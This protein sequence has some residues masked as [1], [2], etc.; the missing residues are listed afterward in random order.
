[1]E[2]WCHSAIKKLFHVTLDVDNENTHL[3]SLEKEL[4]EEGLVPPLKLSQSN[5]DRILL[6]RLFLWNKDSKS[7][8][9]DYLIDIYIN[10]CSYKESESSN[11]KEKNIFFDQAQDL[12]LNYIGLIL[13]MPTMFPQS[14]SIISLGSSLW[15]NSI[16]ERNC[17]KTLLTGLSIDPINSMIIHFE[18]S[19]ILYDVVSNGLLYLRDIAINTCSIDSPSSFGSIIETLCLICSYKQVSDI[20]VRLPSWCPSNN[21][22][23]PNFD[24]ESYLGPLLSIGFNLYDPKSIMLAKSHFDHARNRPISELESS[25]YH[26]RGSFHLLHKAI[27]KF[28]SILLKSSADNKNLVLQY[29]SVLL[30]LNHSRGKMM[31]DPMQVSSDST[32]LNLSCVLLLFCEPFIQTKRFSSVIPD[33][34]I[35]PS[36]LDFS[37]QTRM[38]ATQEQWNEYCKDH[39]QQPYSFITEVYFMTIESY[40]LAFNRCIHI[41]YDLNKNIREL[42][43]T[44]ETVQESRLLNILNERLNNT[45]MSKLVL[46]VLL[47]DKDIITSLDSFWSFTLSWMEKILINPNESILPWPIPPRLEWSCIPEPFLEILAEFYLFKL[48]IAHVLFPRRNIIDNPLPIEHASTIV[49]FI[50]MSTKYVKNPYLIAKLVDILFQYVMSDQNH[51]KLFFSHQM[52]IQYLYPALISFYVEVENT[53]SSSQFYDKFNIRYHISE[54]SKY[55]WDRIPL[56]KD[57][58][59][60]EAK[61]NELFVRFINLLLNDTTYLLDESLS[62]LVQ[63][64]AIQAEDKSIEQESRQLALLERQTETFMMLANDSVYMLSYM[65]KDLIE[66]FMRPEL[67]DRLAAMLDYHLLQ[68]IGPKSL[69]LKVKNPE[70]YHFKPKE[71]LGRLVDIYLHLQGEKKFIQAIANDGRS[72]SRKY[73]ERASQTLRRW[74]IRS[75]KEIL[76]FDKMIDKVEKQMNLLKQNE[77]TEEEIPEEFLDP[78]LATLM[79]D[80]VILTTSGITMD[81]TTIISH[82]LNDKTDPFNRKPLS[83]DQVIPGMMTIIYLNAYFVNRYG[84][85]AKN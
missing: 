71:L 21:Q 48:R 49:S 30:R 75:E 65:T 3:A 47:L 46:D 4:L 79:I 6:S 58:I 36:R 73:F 38:Y 29:I 61:H 72:F 20:I 1:M 55:L 37:N 17:Q 84:I 83:M 7:S 35:L 28:L 18:K 12:V 76:L 25:F 81:R 9:L 77:E 54:I 26:L 59:K 22:T 45:F 42:E 57:R 52:M 74:C 23:A 33:Y 53:G 16:H 15:I 13:Q 11:S 24:K 64:H 44:K 27:H 14:Q 56:H 19:E 82:L 60:Y 39:S 8:I 32:M 66:P 69:E 62:K 67:V 50:F 51:A 43:Q 41:W 40:R 2:D 68:M 31:T 10:I 80:P 34:A 78:V 5:L 70:K 85:K 63:I